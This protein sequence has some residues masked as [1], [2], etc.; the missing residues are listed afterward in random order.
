[1]YLKIY[2]IVALAR[3]LGY[4][5]SKINYFME[6]ETP[7]LQMICDWIMSSDNTNL[8]IEFLLNYLEQ[9]KRY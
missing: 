4:N 8:T 7:A 6:A 5:K 1:M 9:L 3:L 2:V